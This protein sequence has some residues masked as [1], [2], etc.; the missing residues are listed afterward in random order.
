MPFFPRDAHTAAPPDL[1]GAEGLVAAAIELV[2]HR[3]WGYEIP[4]FELRRLASM[5]NLREACAALNA[6]R[7]AGERYASRLLA[8]EAACARVDRH[9]D[10]S[11]RTPGVRA[12]LLLLRSQLWEAIHHSRLPPTIRCETALAIEEVFDRHL[13]AIDP[14]TKLA[15]ETNLSTQLILSIDRPPQQP[16]R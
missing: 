11:C 15:V 16:K 1:R 5:R 8:L 4:Q 3:K 2:V 6:R 13:T 7:R 12:S 10:V 9:L 14:A